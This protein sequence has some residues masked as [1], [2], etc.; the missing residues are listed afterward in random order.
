MLVRKNPFHLVDSSPWP[1][2]AGGV[3]LLLTMGLVLWMHS[4]TFVFV[5]GSFF[6]MVFLVYSWWRDVVREGSYLGFHG[7]MVQKGLR[8]GMML[9]IVSEVFFFLGF[10]WAFF[11]SSLSVLADISEEW[12]PVGLEPM[13]PMGVPLLNTVVL[14]S[15]GVTVTYC[16]YSVL[17]DSF[18]GG[19]MGLVWTLALGFF[20]TLLQL[21]EYVESSFSIADSVYGSVFFMATGFHGFHVIVGSLFLLVCLL[22]MGVGHFSSTQHVGLE[23][24]IWYWHFVDVVWIFL[25]VSIYWWGSV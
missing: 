24:A 8:I 1:I 25:Y 3:A 19:L 4:K 23:C 20:F 22:R 18:G 9:F 10:F 2:V 12:P 14:L 7:V 21:L 15:S 13:D 11:H 16:H 17:T 5:G 6:L